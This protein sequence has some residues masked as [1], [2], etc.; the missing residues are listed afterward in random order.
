MIYN[1]TISGIHFNVIDYFASQLYNNISY[2]SSI[3]S[4]I[5]GVLDFLNDRKLNGIVLKMN[6]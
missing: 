4:F 2:F 5:A 1:N 3:G 6:F